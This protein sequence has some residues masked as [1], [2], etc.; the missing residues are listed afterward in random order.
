MEP[1]RASPNAGQP[2]C[3]ENTNVVRRDHNRNLV[4]RPEAFI[5]DACPSRLNG[6]MSQAA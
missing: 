5:R 1:T 3:H 2:V 6:E 4:S